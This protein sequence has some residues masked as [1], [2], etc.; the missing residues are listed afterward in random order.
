MDNLPIK[1]LY[2]KLGTFISKIDELP[3][4]DIGEP[5]CL[6]TDPCFWNYGDD[7][8]YHDEDGN[9]TDPPEDAP[10]FTVIRFP[11]KEVSPDTQMAF[12]SSNIYTILEPSQALVSEYLIAISD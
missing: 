1:L 10:K 3:G 5:D 4:R 8:H 12:H 6:L 7:G 2:T 11:G 9:H